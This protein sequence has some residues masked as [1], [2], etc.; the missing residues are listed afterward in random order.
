VPTV[1]SQHCIIVSKWRKQNPEANCFV[2]ADC[3]M[4]HRNSL[5]FCADVSHITRDAQVNCLTPIISDL[6]YMISLQAPELHGRSC[7]HAGAAC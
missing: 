3:Q 4:L 6:N 7:R 1:L 2:R 5:I